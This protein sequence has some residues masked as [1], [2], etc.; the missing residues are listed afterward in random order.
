MGNKSRNENTGP[1]NPNLRLVANEEF[2]EGLPYA[3]ENWPE[4][5]DVWGWRTGRRV[6]MNG[7]FHDRYLY[8]PIRLSRPENSAGSNRKQRH[9]FA[10]KTSV[11]RYIR[12]N[13]PDADVA[14]FFASF[15]WRIPYSASANGLFLFSTNS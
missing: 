9:T 15:N 2:G 8:L 1:S 11:E 13:F 4:P 14:A 10:S 3:P 12:A 6:T 7:N 5:G